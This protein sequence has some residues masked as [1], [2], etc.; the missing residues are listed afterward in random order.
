MNNDPISQLPEPYRVAWEI[1]HES[2]GYYQILERILIAAQKMTGASWGMMILASEISSYHFSFPE[3]RT[4]PDMHNSTIPT[5]HITSMAYVLAR[6]AIDD[7]QGIVI[8]DMDSVIP[9]YEGNLINNYLPP[10]T[11]EMIA[12]RAKEEWIASRMLEIPNTSR[13]TSMAIPIIEK[14]EAIGSIYLHRQVSEGSFNNEALQKAQ[15]FLTCIAVSIKN[16]KEASDIKHSGFQILATA[17]S[18]LRTPLIVIRGYAQII[19]DGL[20]KAK[21]ELNR[22]DEIKKFAGIIV[23]NTE[24]VEVVL[25]DLLDY[26]RI[27]E[28]YVYKQ[29]INLKDVFNPILGKYQPLVNEKNQTLILDLPDSLDVEIE[30]EHY[31]SP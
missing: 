10:S 2:L 28:G 22:E 15:T 24:R 19:R 1:L 11:R 23:S 17:S 25:N 31:L 14:D 27:E 3:F 16:T 29:G 4:L 9:S 18:E 13:L 26:A 8:P 7:G 30:A 12:N 20:L 21:E 6:K 5:G